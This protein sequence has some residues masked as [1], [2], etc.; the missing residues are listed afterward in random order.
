M[1]WNNTHQKC[2][3]C[4]HHWSMKRSFSAILPSHKNKLMMM[5]D[6]WHSW[7]IG[8]S[9]AITKKG[10]QHTTK[11]P[12]M[13]ANVLAAFLSRLELVS[14]TVGVF[15]FS[16]EGLNLFWSL[17]EL[18]GPRGGFFHDA[19]MGWGG[20]LIFEGYATDTLSVGGSTSIRSSSPLP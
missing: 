20:Q 17:A 11:A 3:R 6:I 8:N 1:Q 5:G 9:T 14:F 12:V 13:I 15:F 7:Q 18:G 4:R 19:G 16:M 10:I 2:L